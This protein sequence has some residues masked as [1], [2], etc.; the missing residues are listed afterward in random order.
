MIY[1]NETIALHEGKNSDKV[2]KFIS[3]NEDPKECSKTYWNAIKQA[4]NNGS[5]WGLYL[6]KTGRI[7]A[8]F[9]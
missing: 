8:Q 7:K 5:L 6:T 2:V 1:N 3:L 4:Y 9:I